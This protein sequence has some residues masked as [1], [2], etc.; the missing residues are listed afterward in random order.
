MT[1]E[2]RNVRLSGSQDVYQYSFALTHLLYLAFF[3]FFSSSFL[4]NVMHGQQGIFLD[5]R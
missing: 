3:F 5:P 4:S 1:D 2:I